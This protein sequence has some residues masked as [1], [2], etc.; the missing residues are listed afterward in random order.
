MNQLVEITSQVQVNLNNALDTQWRYLTTA[1][2]I[3][4]QQELES[5]PDAVAYINE[6]ERLLETDRHSSRL[7]LLDSRGGCYDTGGTHGVWS[8]LDILAG[9]EGQY[10]YIFMLTRTRLISSKPTEPG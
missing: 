8:D 2:N 9:G 7:V 1:V 5:V 4:E 10:T 3:L 6:L